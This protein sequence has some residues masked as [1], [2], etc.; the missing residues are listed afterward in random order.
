MD[1]TFCS[2]KECLKFETCPRA[3]TDAVWDKA[4]RAGLGVAQYLDPTELECFAPQK[5][6]LTSEAEP[7]I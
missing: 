3:L 1:M 6:V 7:T 2:A 5:K 4:E